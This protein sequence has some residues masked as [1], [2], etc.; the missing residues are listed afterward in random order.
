MIK[1]AEA[2]AGLDKVARGFLSETAGEIG[3]I[4]RS[5][6]R[7]AS[8]VHRGDSHAI[9]LARLIGGAGG[10]TLGALGG[11]GVSAVLHNALADDEKRSLKHY[12]RSMLAGGTVGG[13]GGAALGVSDTGVKGLD[14]ALLWTHK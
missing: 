8:A 4:V 9:P 5:I 10:G 1:T 2:V 7:F 13:L 12:L 11:A 14:N 6:P 3:E